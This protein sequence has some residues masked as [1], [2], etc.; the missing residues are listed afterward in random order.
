MTET[1]K[2]VRAWNN[3][4]GKIIKRGERRIPTWRGTARV[5]WKAYGRVVSKG[6]TREDAKDTGIT[7]ARPPSQVE[8]PVEP[9]C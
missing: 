4:K 5:T 9:F 7:Q 6:I 8:F 1:E 3:F 2:P